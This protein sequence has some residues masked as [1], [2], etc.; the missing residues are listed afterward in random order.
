MKK[1]KHQYTMHTEFLMVQFNKQV[2][3]VIQG[4]K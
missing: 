1:T 4:M 3:L 2:K